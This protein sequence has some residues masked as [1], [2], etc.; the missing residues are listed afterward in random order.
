M[1][2]GTDGKLS[3]T[4]GERYGHFHSGGRPSRDDLSI[5][6][7]D[8]LLGSYDRL[9]SELRRRLVTAGEHN[10]LKFYLTR[11]MTR[12]GSAIVASGVWLV[13]KNRAL[14]TR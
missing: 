3:I 11:A 10:I 13:R 4:V 6:L 8:G 5:E 14:S 2:G 12:M 9:Q 7:F 1:N